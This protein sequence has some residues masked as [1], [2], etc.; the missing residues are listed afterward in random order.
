MK[1]D[2]SFL[3]WGQIW[4]HWNETIVI[5]FRAV[6]SRHHVYNIRRYMDIQTH[7]NTLMNY[8]HIRRTPADS[9]N[10]ILWCVTSWGVLCM[11]HHS[12]HP[13]WAHGR[14]RPAAVMSSPCSVLLIQ[15]QCRWNT[16]MFNVNE[17]I[18]TSWSLFL[19]FHRNEQR[20]LRVKL[21]ISDIA[22]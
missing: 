19:I 18:P 13:C 2:D 10:V 4:G 12:H 1:Q 3:K 22:I 15:F 21:F 20:D 5:S 6:S 8:Y 14:R 17:F 16:N 11:W 9:V 7:G